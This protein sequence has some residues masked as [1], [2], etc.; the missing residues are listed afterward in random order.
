MSKRFLGSLSG[1]VLLAASMAA[2]ALAGEAGCARA[3][4]P[5][6]V[7]NAVVSDLD[8]LIDR[9]V[10]SKDGETVGTVEDVV[11][12]ACDDPLEIVV[13]KPVGPD[14]EPQ[15]IA[16]APAGIRFEAGETAITLTD[17][18][19]A[20]VRALPNYQ[21]DD[22]LVSLNRDMAPEAAPETS[23]PK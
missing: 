3:D 21:Y 10:V 14:E 6:K 18:T 11:L 16:V 5:P 12:D 9:A 20:Q 15:A 22:A 1:L 2:P 4:E 19:A 7:G 17:L 8:D 13:A 23:L